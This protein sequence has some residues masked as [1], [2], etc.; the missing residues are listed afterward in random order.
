[1]EFQ[2]IASVVKWETNSHHTGLDQT[3]KNKPTHAGQWCYAVMEMVAYRKPWICTEPRNALGQGPFPFPVM[4]RE[5]LSSILLVST[6]G[7]KSRREKAKKR[8]AK[9]SIFLKY[10]NM[11]WRDVH[12][13]SESDYIKTGGTFSEHALVDSWVEAS[14][15]MDV[16]SLG[17][18]Q[19]K[20]TEK[21][22]A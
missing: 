3:N 17:N 6:L 1:M 18:G 14:K 2:L 10:L 22:T 13:H 9:A 20:K 7:G 16:W 8:S 19:K 4:W 12:P 21:Y 11:S 5:A 15:K